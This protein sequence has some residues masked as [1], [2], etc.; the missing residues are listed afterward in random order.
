MSLSSYMLKDYPVAERHLAK[1]AGVRASAPART[2]GEKREEAKNEAWMTLILARLDLVRL[3]AQHLIAPAFKFQRELSSR[4]DNDHPTPAAR[5]GTGAS[6]LCLTPP[7]MGD[8]AA[9]LAEAAALIDRLPPTMANCAALRHHPQHGIADEQ[10][11][12]RKSVGAVLRL[13]KRQ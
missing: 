12:R 9:Q 1:V 6:P 4:N 11:S 3:E 8:S 5:S 7:G 2:L 13:G 10:K